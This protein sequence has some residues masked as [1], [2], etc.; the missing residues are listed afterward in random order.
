[1]STFGIRAAFLVVLGLLCLVAVY[2]LRHDRPAEDAT[3]LA[4]VAAVPG[5]PAEYP[6]TVIEDKGRLEIVRPVQQPLPP[7]VVEPLFEADARLTLNETAKLKFAAHDRASGRPLSGATVTASVTQGKG[8]ALPLSV[9]EVEDGVF[10]VPFTPRGPGQ[11]QIALNVDGVPSGS[12][13]VGVVGAVGAADNRVDIVDP[14][15]VDPRSPR[16]R[17]SGRSRRR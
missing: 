16:S 14:L 11:F 3:N 17:T 8:P 1:V 6:R 13:K 10:E 2:F 9:E 4:G 5:Q 7:T 12:R 15:S